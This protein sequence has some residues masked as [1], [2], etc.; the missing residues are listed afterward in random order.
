M[1]RRR[2]VSPTAHS[3]LSCQKRM[4]RKEALEN[5]IALRAEKT[6]RSVL[7]VFVTQA[8]VRTPFGRAAEFLPSKILLRQI[9]VPAKSKSI[10]PESMRRLSGFSRFC[11]AASIGCGRETR[12]A[13]GQK[14][15]NSA[16]KRYSRPQ[17]LFFAYFFLTSQKKV[18]RRRH[19]APSGEKTKPE[20]IRLRASFLIAAAAHTSR[21]RYPRSGCPLRPSARR[22]RKTLLPSRFRCCCARSEAPP[23]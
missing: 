1:R 23:P 6:C 17:R 7:R 11:S 10:C 3:F 8:V 14:L 22:N 2:G 9:F 19:P 13:K 4:G 20:G 16:R 21:R 5:E 12:Q 15:E 18:C